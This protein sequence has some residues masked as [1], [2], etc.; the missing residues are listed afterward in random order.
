MHISINR[1]HLSLW[2][3]VLTLWFLFVGAGLII[4][5]PLHPRQDEVAFMLLLPLL[6][7]APYIGW[8]LLV[9]LA[10][11]WLGPIG[12][13]ATHGFRWP[14]LGKRGIQQRPG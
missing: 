1:S 12:R 13:H 7:L 4:G 8:C 5:A 11:T 14:L 9:A 3:K 6:F 10:K 2:A